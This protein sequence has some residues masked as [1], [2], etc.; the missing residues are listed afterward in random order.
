MSHRR[1]LGR[2]IFWAPEPDE[3]EADL[4]E[5]EIEQNRIDKEDRDC[6]AAYVAEDFGDLM[7][8]STI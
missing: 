8:G 4:T 1:I 3:P 6:D 2:R 7:R 5:D